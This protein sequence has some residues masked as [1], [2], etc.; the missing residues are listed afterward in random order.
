VSPRR[1]PRARRAAR[2]RPRRLPRRG[3][4]ATA[5]AAGR[6]AAP[7]TPARA[8]LLG[9]GAPEAILVGV[10]ALILFGPKGL[11][12]AAKS[13]GATLRAFAPTIREITQVSSELKSTLE[14]EIG[15]NDL[16]DEMAGR[17]TAP[18]ARAASGAD[19]G[20]SLSELREGFA[21]GDDDPDIE[22]KRADSVRA[23][24]G[25]AAPGGSEPEAAPMAAMSMD[26]LEA[27]LAR[28]RAAAAKPPQELPQQLSADD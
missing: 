14:N 11:A 22:R 28:R 25:G 5:A 8:S 16:R 10:V 21:G 4:A 26:D 12:Q 23:A 15:L 3:P 18:R 24:W 1:T 17:P 13:L 7:A 19:A 9:V 27:E 20:P 6:R 2:P